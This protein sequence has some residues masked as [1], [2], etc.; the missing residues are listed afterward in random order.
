MTDNDSLRAAIIRTI[1]ALEEVVDQ[2]PAPA[3]RT[4]RLTVDIPESL[5]HRM[6]LACAADRQNMTDAVRALLERHWP[7]ERAT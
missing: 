6:K 1:E 5:H 2:L 4:K 3:E 7:P